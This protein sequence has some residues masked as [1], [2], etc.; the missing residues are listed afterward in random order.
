MVRKVSAICGV[1]HFIESNKD[2]LTNTST[3]PPT[4]NAVSLE[5]LHEMRIKPS[6]EIAN[7]SVETYN[8]A[9][10]PSIKVMLIFHMSTGFSSYFILIGFL[11]LP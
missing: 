7:S 3:P 8:A 5:A 4:K 6:N 1:R 9:T 10:I 11:S 2:M